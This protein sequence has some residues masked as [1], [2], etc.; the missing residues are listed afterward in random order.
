MR[1]ELSHF[2]WKFYVLTYSTLKFERFD[3]KMS[4]AMLIYVLCACISWFISTELCMMMYYIYIYIHLLAVDHVT[5]GA[6]NQE[7]Y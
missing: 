7:N 2:L 1:A 6:S 5:H 4:S 3:F